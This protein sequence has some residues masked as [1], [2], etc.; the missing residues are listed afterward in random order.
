MTAAV[1]GASTF[2]EWFDVAPD[3]MIAVD[4]AGRIVR[5][6]PRAEDLFGFPAGALRD[7]PIE[8]LI[9]QRAR[10]AHRQHMAHYAASPRIRPMGSG[11]ELVG[12]R[13]DGREF[14]VEV[15]LSPIATANGPLYMASIRDISESQRARQALARARYD[16]A[17]ARIGQLMLGAPNL[18]AAIE[19]VPAQVSDSLDG[20]AAAFAFRAS[21]REPM[22]LHAAHGVSAD[23]LDEAL[24]DAPAASSGGGVATRVLDLSV[25]NPAQAPAW[26]ALAT[27]GFAEAAWVP[28]PGDG[29]TEGV[30]LVLSR[31]THGFSRDALHFLQS[32]A[33]MLASAIR[34][35]RSEEQLSHAQRLEA[36]GQLTG[37]IA[38]DF[39]NLLTIISGNLQILEDEAG[40]EAAWR[41]T[42]HSALRAVDRGSELTRK[43][44][45]FARRQQLSPR[46]CNVAGLLRE[47]GAMMRRTLGDAIDL[48]MRCPADIP[49]V[50][51]DP[52]QLDTALLNLAVNARDAMPRGGRLDIE[53]GMRHEPAEGGLPFV[54]LSVRD[55]GLGMSE[56]VLAHALEPFFTTKEQGKGTGLGLSMVYG[57]VKQSGG[58]LTVDSRLGYG[59]CI[60]L[61]LPA[62]QGTHAVAERPGE[63]AGARGEET[64]LVV[65]DEPEVRRVALAFL[66]SLG[67][68]TLAAANAEEA[69]AQLA[70]HPDV[71]ML[72]SDVMLGG[73]MT[74]VELA[75][76]AGRLRP[77]LPVLLTSGDERS[78]HGDGSPASGPAFLRKPYRREALSAALRRLLD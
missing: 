34:R 56:E 60:E 28:L 27:A 13:H 37:G 20:A 12:L 71:A 59:T 14:P 29:T 68:A 48:R 6:N 75:H 55:T 63:A 53:A 8:A 35:M 57:F 21:P 15:A 33:M 51:V 47:L 10:S 58:H 39:N 50:F 19:D 22:R 40:A 67:Y 17:M 76:E 30:L 43:L 42:I 73:G 65:E 24:A 45:A 78:L 1:L 3:A 46:A 23:L 72:F 18:E 25:I 69:L 41:D 49:D 66:R 44:L 5:A 74:G 64:I 77:G 7:L 26:A 2:S 4:A 9:P 32:V 70:R 61:H 62:L 38:H 54:V 16:S 36:I 52:A 11:Q 31:G